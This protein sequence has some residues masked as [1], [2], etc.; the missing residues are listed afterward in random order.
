MT[1]MESWT[2]VQQLADALEVESMS[3]DGDEAHALAVKT[4]RFLDRELGM[5]TWHTR[6]ILC[7]MADTIEGR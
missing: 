6:R 7:A 4:A 5:E 2:E 1:E 3:L